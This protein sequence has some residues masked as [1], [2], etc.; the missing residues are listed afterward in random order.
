VLYRDIYISFKCT[1]N[2]QCSTN[3]C[4]D[5]L[6]I[7]NEKKKNQLNF[8]LTNII[9]LLFLVNVCIIITLNDVILNIS[10]CTL[11]TIFYIN[12]FINNN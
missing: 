3:K 11:I 5:D 10:K 9:T 2:T 8:V 1:S 4:I 12:T 7:F 6:C